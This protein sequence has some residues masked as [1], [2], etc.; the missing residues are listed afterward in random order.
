METECSFTRLEVTKEGAGRGAGG[1]QSPVG[2]DSI[3]D[4]LLQLWDISPNSVAETALI[5]P[6]AVDQ[7]S[8]ALSWELLQTLRTWGCRSNCQDLVP[9]HLSSCGSVSRGGFGR[10]A[11][12]PL[13][14][15]SLSARPG[16][17]LYHSS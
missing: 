16:G 3:S 15:S 13:S 6:V 10:E 9:L 11:H 17:P 8:A 4:L 2:D 1:S 12:V 7:E 5:L 14:V